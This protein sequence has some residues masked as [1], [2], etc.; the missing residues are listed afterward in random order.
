M[1]KTIIY[2]GALRVF[3]D[4][5]GKEFPLLAKF[6]NNRSSTCPNIQL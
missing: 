2:F 5:K 6:E 3:L 4:A 1:A